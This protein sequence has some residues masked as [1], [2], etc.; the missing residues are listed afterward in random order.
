MALGRCICF[1]FL[2]LSTADALTVS[3]N[4]LGLTSIP[5]YINSAVSILY[6]AN[7]YITEIRQTDF[8]DMY[9]NLETLSFYNNRRSYVED[10][11]FRGTVLKYI[12]LD[13]NQ[14]TTFP[15][16]RQVNMTMKTISISLGKISRITA[17]DVNYLTALEALY[18]D[19]NPLIAM[20]DFFLLLPKLTTLDLQK[21]SFSCCSEKAWMKSVSN[22]LIDTTPCES[23]P[24]LIGVT[25]SSITMEQ[26]EMEACR[27]LDNFALTIIMHLHQVFFNTLV[28][29]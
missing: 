4:N 5:E 2:F 19:Q 25:W 21:I 23:P 29:N 24:S 14:L 6:L 12:S 3:Y 17:E 26:L 11:C 22:L 16:F 8:N 1:T 18:L 9:P 20:P 15:D 7:N 10:G 27:E 13:D 28:F